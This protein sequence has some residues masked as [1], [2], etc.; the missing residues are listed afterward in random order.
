MAEPRKPH[1][2]ALARTAAERIDGSRVGVVV[3]AGPAGVRV[4]F[5]GNRRGPLPARVSAALDD[6]ALAQAARDRQ[7][8][9]LVFEGG[10]PGRPVLIALLRS[11][12]PLLDAALAAR[13]PSARRTARVDGQRVEIEG[14][15]EVVLRC[16]KASLTLRADG[17]V[18]LR[19][20]DVVSQADRVQKV[21]GGK[22]QIN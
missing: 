10:E 8:A 13:L 12:S 7:E 11:A 15:E 1:A 9:L 2:L 21:R 4:D 19:G 3:S 17:R 6:A 5:D 22:V 16:G 18:L 14:K 20:V